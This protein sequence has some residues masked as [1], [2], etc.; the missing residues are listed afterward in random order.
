MDFIEEKTP[1]GYTIKIMPASWQFMVFDRKG[2]SVYV[3]SES[4]KLVQKLL[5]LILSAAIS[6]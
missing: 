5:L 1:A 6:E 4:K 2:A 3:T